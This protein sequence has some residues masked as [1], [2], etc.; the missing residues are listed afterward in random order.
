MAEENN[1]LA[2]L[3]DQRKH[4]VADGVGVYGDCG[5]LRIDLGVTA[6]KIDNECWET[7]FLESGNE[8]SIERRGLPSA[9]DE[10]YGWVGGG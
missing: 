9:G 1:I 6:G 8:G 7:C 5:G 4:D 10:D 3:L 2:F